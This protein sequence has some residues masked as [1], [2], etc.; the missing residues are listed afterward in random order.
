MGAG[1]SPDV[2]MD[3]F[4]TIDPNPNC[5][6]V[7][8]MLYHALA[9]PCVVR[10]IRVTREREDRWCWVT[11]V[12]P[13]GHWTAAQAHKIADS[14]SGVAYLIVGGG[15]GLRFAEGDAVPR[16]DLRDPAQWG[17]PYKIYGDPKDLAFGPPRPISP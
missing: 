8:G 7:D 11:G 4:L 9:A 2:P 17:E 1:G 10:R 16:W 6:A 5:D 13:G 15:W 14:G 3:L 12:E